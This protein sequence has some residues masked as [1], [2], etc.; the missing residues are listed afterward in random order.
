MR[1]SVHADLEVGW[2]RGMMDIFMASFF[3]HLFVSI[4]QTE[5]GRVTLLILQQCLKTDITFQKTVPRSKSGLSFF[6]PVNL[7]HITYM[8]MHKTLRLFIYVCCYRNKVNTLTDDYNVPIDIWEKY[9]FC[10]Q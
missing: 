7:K 4:Y 1:E 5:Q 9:G 10:K 2:W 8:F 6:N 3:P